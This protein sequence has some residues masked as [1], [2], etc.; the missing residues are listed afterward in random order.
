MEATV[1]QALVQL[2]AD[3]APITGDAVKALVVAER[4]PTVPDLVAPVVDLRHYDA[5]LVE[6]AS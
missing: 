1:E 2:L 5:L 6:L 4:R 3:G